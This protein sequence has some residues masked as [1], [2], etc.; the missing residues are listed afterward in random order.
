VRARAREIELVESSSGTV[1]VA[2]GLVVTGIESAHDDQGGQI[3]GPNTMYLFQMGG[4]R[5]LHMGDIGDPKLTD[6]QK[7]LIGKVDVLFIPVGGVTTLGPRQAKAVVDALNPGAVFPMHYGD[8]R[9]YRLEPVEKFAS[10]FP[11][12]NVRRAGS[13]VR[14][15]PSDLTDQPIVYILTAQT[16]N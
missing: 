14:V 1:T 16:R 7:K 3:Y 6:Y 12:E 2:A 9:F 15:R 11:P 10:L 4:L 5:C 8:I 13:S